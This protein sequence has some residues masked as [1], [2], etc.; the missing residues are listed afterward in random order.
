MSKDKTVTGTYRQSVS[1]STT[2]WR[3][4]LLLLGI[5]L[6]LTNVVELAAT[7]RP[8]YWEHFGLIGISGSVDH[9]KLRVSPPLDRTASIA[10][11][12]TSDTAIPAVEPGLSL[13]HI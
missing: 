11:S 10:F 1:S 3:V 2:A 7:F 12:R 9:D 5:V 13:I 6:G 4:A 8:D